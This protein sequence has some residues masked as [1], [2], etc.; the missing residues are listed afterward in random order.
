MAMNVDILEAKNG[1]IFKYVVDTTEGSYAFRSDKGKLIYIQK[2]LEDEHRDICVLAYC[3]LNT[4]AYIII[5]GSNKKTVAEY[6][7]AVNGD[8]YAVSGQSGY[9]FRPVFEITKIKNKNLAAVINGVH[10]LA[11]N[12]DPVNYPYCSY[13]YLIDGK[14]DAVV[15]IKNA[16]GNQN[17]TLDEFEKQMN[18]DVKIKQ[19]AMQQVESYAV[20]MEQIKKRYIADKAPTSE[21]NIIFA[22]GEV[23]DRTK[24]SYKKVVQKMGIDKNRRDLMI[25][26]ICDMI[27]RKHYTVA[28]VIAKLKLDKENLTG[29]IL[30][31]MAEFNRVYNYSYDYIVS[32]LGVYDPNYDLMAKLIRGIHKQHGDS[33]E[34]ICVRFHLNSNLVALRQKCGL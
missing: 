24:L 13:S 1:V 14:T 21:T 33:F 17:L 3:I 4:K 16:E 32:V 6:I 30:E 15:I 2:L 18:S 20:V 19:K 12:G 25:G 11:P 22:I 9:P 7:K 34:T 29:I 31:V 26:V 5:K 27:I 23:C 28:A 8:F 10:K